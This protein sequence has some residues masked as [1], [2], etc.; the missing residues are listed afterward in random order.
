MVVMR[1]GGKMVARETHAQRR[2]V[3]STGLAVRESSD[4]ISLLCC[5]GVVW[6][7]VQD[8][9]GVGVLAGHADAAL[10]DLPELPQRSA[11]QCIA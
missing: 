9:G 6:V 8:S 2:R 10:R 3:N 11:E 4:D 1:M 7:S 5:S